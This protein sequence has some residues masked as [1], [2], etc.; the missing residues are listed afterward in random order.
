[1]VSR[2]E[3]AVPGQDRFEKR[4]R[5]FDRQAPGSWLRF[6]MALARSR[7]LIIRIPPCQEQPK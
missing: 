7:S 4:R 2:L 6:S 1:M 5:S 3:D